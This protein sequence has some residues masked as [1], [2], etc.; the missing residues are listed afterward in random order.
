MS[1]S[2]AQEIIPGAWQGS[3]KASNNPEFLLQRR[4][5]LIMRVH[6][7]RTAL[8]Q[9]FRRPLAVR[10]VLQSLGTREYNIALFDSPTSALSDYFDT[11]VELVDRYRAIGGGV[12]IYCDAGISRSTTLTAAYL[13]TLR[14]L[15]G[16]HYSSARDAVEDVLDDI[17]TVR[18]GIRPNAGFY[19][20]LVTYADRLGLII[21]TA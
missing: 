8:N 3:L 20:Q 15:E 2:Q 21:L 1:L 4:F 7:P 10:R 12:L 13:L 11:V 5:S 9:D 16:W 19:Q 18:P 14:Q 17:R 6:N